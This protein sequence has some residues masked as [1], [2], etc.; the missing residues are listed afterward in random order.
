MNLNSPLFDRIRL[1]SSPQ[2][3]DVE[4]PKC[5][6][7]GCLGAGLH[8]APKGRMREGQY[9]CFCLDHVRAYNQSY[10]YFNGMSDEDVVR[11]QRDSETGHRPTWTMGVNR[12][13]RSRTASAYDIRGRMN[14]EDGPDFR[15]PGRP[16]P[17]ERARPRYGLA[18]LKSLEALGLD[19]TADAESVKARYKELVKRLHPDANG[20]DR[21]SEDRLREI[22]HAYKYLRSAKLV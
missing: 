21:S 12:A 3:A 9:F 22:I 5:D 7:P 11:Y 6:Y 14:S 2:A 20:G 15:D 1:K 17:E 18:A 4:Q 8:R 19:D 16:S 10:N 13:A